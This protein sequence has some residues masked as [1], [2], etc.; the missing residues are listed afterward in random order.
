M[1]H[2]EQTDASTN[3]WWHRQIQEV[4]NWAPGG[5]LV[6]SFGQTSSIAPAAAWFTT[7]TGLTLVDGRQLF[8]NIL[9]VAPPG[10]AASDYASRLLRTIST[11]YNES[12]TEIPPNVRIALVNPNTIFV[13]SDCESILDRIAAMP[14]SSAVG[15][16][17][18]HRLR[19]NQ[20]TTA[21][22]Q[23]IK[24]HTGLSLRHSTTEVLVWPH[25]FALLRQLLSLAEQRKLSVVVLFEQFAIEFKSFP[26]D[27]CN[28][29]KLAVIST[30]NDPV[31]SAMLENMLTAET[32]RQAQGSDA[33]LQHIRVKFIEPAELAQA[34]G[35]ILAAE[36][37]WY[38]AWSVM[39][40][41]L[42][43]LKHIK[44]P[45]TLVNLAV[46]ASAC[47]EADE[48]SDI[49][50]IA[51][52]VGFDSVEQLNSAALVSAEI[53]AWKILDD[54]LAR[55]MT[56]FP[57]HPLTVSRSYNRLMMTNRYTEAANLAAKAG[58]PFEAAWA[59]INTSPE[60]NWSEFLLM[61]KTA[62]RESEA[63]ENAVNYFLD[64]GSLEKA[65]DFFEQIPLETTNGSKRAMLLLEIVTKEMQF[66]KEDADLEA[67]IN[68]FS[69]L[70]L[71]VAT[72]PTDT[73]LRSRLIH[74]LEISLDDPSRRLV[75]ISCCLTAFKRAEIF[76]SV[77]NANSESSPF[78]FETPEKST[79]AAMD[80]MVAVSESNKSQPLGRGSLP[81]KY[82]TG[83]PDQ[84][85]SGLGI[86]VHGVT[87]A[88]DV[89]SIVI[90]LHCLSIATRA[91]NTAT[92]DY[93]CATQLLS[94]L[95]VH[96]RVTDAMNI[97]ESI[98][99]F[100][101]E[102]HPE[103]HAERLAHAWAS[104]AEVYQRSRNPL[105]ALL[106]LTICLEAMLKNPS[107]QHASLLKHK[108]RLGTRIFRDLGLNDFARLFIAREHAL[109]LAVPERER[110]LK[111]IVTNETFCRLGD[112]DRNTTAEQFSAICQLA[113]DL[114]DDPTETEWGTP[115][116]LGVSLLGI[117]RILGFNVADSFRKLV[118]NRIPNCPLPFQRLF[119]RYLLDYPKLADVEAQM[120]DLVDGNG[121][122][123]QG[124]GFSLVEG[125]LRRA[126]KSACHH[127]DPELFLLAAAWLSQPALSASRTTWQISKSRPEANLAN[128][129]ELFP[130][131]HEQPTERMRDYAHAMQRQIDK[132][133]SHFK[134]FQPLPL[135]AVRNVATE[136][137]A[138]C[139]LVYDSEQYLCRLVLR[140]GGVEGPTRIDKTD[141]DQSQ[142]IEWQKRHPEDYSW[143]RRY[144]A[145]GP[146]DTPDEEEIRRSLFRLQAQ[147]PTDCKTTVVLPEAEL[148]GFTFFLNEIQGR[149]VG[150]LTQ[151]VTAPSLH[152]LSTVRQLPK[153]NSILLKAW[154]GHPT[155]ADNAVMRPRTEL[156]PVLIQT[157]AEIIEADTPHLL[158]QADVAI[159]LSHGSRGL[160][161]GFV[162]FN[163]VGKF[164]IDELT[165]WLGSCKCVVLFV[166]N[167]GRNDSRIDNNETFGI[168]GRLLKR[169]VRAVIAPPAPLR[170]DLPAV[171]LPP[172]LDFLKQG[173]S[174]G[175][176]HGAG[177][178][179]VRS[180]FSNPCAWG[181]LQLFGDPDLSFG[182]KK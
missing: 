153:P 124:Y 132:T 59:L 42:E 10:F 151:C 9:I 121:I 138:F 63:L 69:S 33:A 112:V 75:L 64:K 68:D 111:E 22:S 30:Q 61:A 176:A 141:W 98:L 170:N 119:H 70:L 135:S 110:E 149:F 108:L 7:A 27:I 168:V 94:T 92:W 134:Y 80:F 175:D 158:K 179:A 50:C 182:P 109:V 180:Q 152:W 154:L 116:S 97:A 48:A 52:V 20:L 114:L 167:S 51:L 37:R 127:Q 15:I 145:F 101:P 120:K 6:V 81:P 38:E 14:E 133:E 137:E 60:P 45:N 79:E 73:N 44:S 96:G 136:D 1:T 19:F 165:E 24:T 4:P 67:A 72:H 89:N 117:S 86:L 54:V 91:R 131:D 125:F 56:E 88:P 126:I 26:S 156:R 178:A 155:L 181:A 163:D 123:D 12:G 118:I 23:T 147:I 104:L 161:R 140:R 128:I 122:D 83:V 144:D 142:Y 87:K 32:I 160:F 146:Y 35:Q 171:W 106:H 139:F 28:H 65:K 162:G 39:K 55:M 129:L 85:M 53:Q 143:D 164:T 99:F 157:G 2:F 21:N 159:L 150:E 90:L 5:V 82:L 84:V 100:W 74:I 115:V 31:Q 95:V 103:F 130:A 40:P 49:L 34:M 47:G 71:Y 105:I 93:Q 43:V 13:A 8:E 169:D 177:Y 58:H 46:A 102:S 66:S 3:E 172:F 148:F 78:N 57:N 166:C 62:H 173:K 77:D 16:F 29:P 107:K 41:Q 113:H 11:A 17:S 18:A 76:F 174:V 36:G 25:F